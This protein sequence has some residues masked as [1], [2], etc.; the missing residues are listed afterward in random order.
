LFSLFLALNFDIELLALNSEILELEVE[1]NRKEDCRTEAV[2]LSE[3]ALMEFEDANTRCYLFAEFYMETMER[4]QEN[5]YMGREDIEMKEYLQA[6]YQ[7]KLTQYCQDRGICHF[8][9]AFIS[10][11]MVFPHFFYTETVQIESEKGEMEYRQ[12]ERDREC[13]AMEGEDFRTRV[14]LMSTRKNEM[15]AQ[16][17]VIE[18]RIDKLKIGKK[19]MFK[20]CFHGF[21]FSTFFANRK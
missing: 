8:F 2:R 10:H 6:F 1:T 16:L 17:E 7:A 12:L 5:Q 3:N 14:V 4:Y 21:H 11:F 20:D 13:N 18:N 9:H 15:V 19:I